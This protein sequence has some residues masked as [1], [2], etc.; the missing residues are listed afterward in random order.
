MFIEFRHIKSN[1]KRCRVPHSCGCFCRKGG[2]RYSRTQRQIHVSRL[3]KHR[4]QRSPILHR[5][6]LAQSPS[7][8]DADTL[9]R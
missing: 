4:K 1:Q 2:K 3:R 6:E 7:S 9:V 5:I 8:S